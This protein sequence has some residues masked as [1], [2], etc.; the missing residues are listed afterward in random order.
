VSTR[1]APRLLL[2]GVLALALVAAACSSSDDGADPPAST[3]TSIMA[4]APDIDQ[5]AAPPTVSAVAIPDGQIAEA[6]ESLDGIAEEALATTGVPGMAIAVVHDDEVVYAKGFGVRDTSTGDPVD[7]DTVFQIASLSKPVGA[8]VV[9]RLVGEGD[10]AWDD[11][12]VEHL[13]N[14][15]LSDPM[16]TAQLTVADLYAH[17][18]GLPDHAGDLLE[19]LGYDQATILE[20]MRLLPLDPFRDSYAYTNFGLTAAA[21]AV[22]AAVGTEWADLSEREIYEPLGM[23]STSSRFADYQAAADRAATHVEVDGSWEPLLVRDPDAQSPAGGVSSSVADMAQWL[24]MVLAEGTYDGQQL[25]DPDALA[26]ITTPQALSGPPATPD[27]RSGFYG[28]GMNVGNDWTGRV[29][30]SHSGAFAMG[31]ATA[32][33]LLP[34]EDLGIVVLTNG[35]P[36]GLPESVAATFMDLV[37]VGQPERDWLAAFAPRFAQM[38]ANPSELA[39]EEPPELPAPARADEAYLGTYLNDYY[40]AMEIVVGDDGGLAIALGPV[41]QVHPL[42][43]WDGDVFAYEPTGEMTVGISAVIFTVGSDGRATS[44]VVENLDADDL[45]T[46]TRA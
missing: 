27:S 43:H 9:A 7:V 32:F 14:F 23:T 19:D 6:V 12:V 15:A 40:G 1:P 10:V 29:R 20:R 26:A 46:F 42:E 17:R 41:P 28:L 38:E 39:G 11:L 45:G 4:T 5:S 3:T 37:E 22:A 16:A 34:S 35:A 18:S 25:V 31:A 30:L 33:T 24:R 36:M 2:I 8:T 13:P 21:E 44:V